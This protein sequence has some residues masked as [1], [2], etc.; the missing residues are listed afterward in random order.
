STVALSATD[1]VLEWNSIMLTTTAAQNPFFQ[2]RFAAI[3]QVAVF[4]AVNTIDQDFDPYL[5]TLTAPRG[6]SDQ[7]A[8]IAAAHAVLR[9]YFPANVAALDAAYAASL[10]GI[11][12]GRRKQDGI[13]VG[14]AA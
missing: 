12:D 6:A 13:A 7:A 4:E 3:T 9:N 11:P 10:A 5:G 2:A 14:E 1:P 8:A